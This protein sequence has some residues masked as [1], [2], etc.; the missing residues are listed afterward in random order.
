[1]L[2]WSEIIQSPSYGLTIQKLLASEVTWFNTSIDE[3][4]PE[5][6][7]PWR[8]LT[9]PKPIHVIDTKS[10]IKSLWLQWNS[11]SLNS[12][13][14]TWLH[15]ITQYQVSTHQLQEFRFNNE[16][17]SIH[18]CRHSMSLFFSSCLYHANYEFIISICIC[19]WTLLYLTYSETYITHERSIHYHFCNTNLPQ[20]G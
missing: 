7:G 9:I 19:R 13:Y 14:I 16:Y 15:R 2:C 11:S 4:T 18:C 17:C 5:I 6:T 1:M 12:Q 8:Q 20:R 10:Y 3:L